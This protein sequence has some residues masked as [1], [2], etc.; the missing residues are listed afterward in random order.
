ML[1]EPH[2]APRPANFQP[3]TPLDLIERVIE[4]MP[5]RVAMI[6]NE[7][8][9]TYAELGG[10][11]AAFHDWLLAR[12]V[13]PGD[14]VSIMAA[15]R[16]EM[17]AA[18]IAVPGLGAV[19][20]AINTRLDAGSVATILDHAGSS[21]MISDDDCRQ[22]ATE[23]AARAGVD[24]QGL[25][26]ILDA[27]PAPLP[28]YSATIHD[29]WQPIC[30]N[31]TSGTTGKPKG[32]VYHH[33]GAYLNTLGVITAFGFD[34]KTRYLSVVPMFHCNGWCHAWAVAAAGGTY[35]FVDRPDPALLYAAIAEH[36]V[37]HIACAPVVLTMM[38]N[39]P[40]RATR[41]PTRR[42]SIGTGGSA[43]TSAL[44]AEL[45]TLGFDL[46]HLYGLTE[47]YGPATICTLTDDQAAMDAEA[48]A[49]LLARQG[50]RHLTASR[51]MVLDE[52]GAEV[53][54]NGETQ[55][56]ITLRGNTLMAG[57]YKD[58]EATDAAFSGDAFRTGDIAVR[59]PDGQVEIRDR[60]K[61][62][63]ISGGENISSLEIESVL[64]RHNAVMLAA[65]VAMPDDTW[66]EIPC[67]YIEP[68]PGETVDAT[69]LDAFC[70]ENL[71]GFKVPRRFVFTDLPKTATGKIQ[72]FA[73][74][75]RARSEAE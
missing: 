50:R 25:P 43:P 9:W 3:L 59:H 48:R 7:R 36:E 32:V 45:D 74:R 30:L 24:A 37:T 67:A 17:V 73:L 34:A 64:H 14:V 26:D 1:R 54:A 41:D 12:G 13:G 68:R 38:L 31:Y 21:V 58:A 11:V 69:I 29:E 56:E 23:A 62:I 5:E 35:V 33:R 63:I 53:P 18:H 65:V 52:T 44:I 57:Y 10:M 27:L 61:D 2:L 28:D 60:S 55:G 75:E 15:N 47:S 40:D 19:L 39:H 8:R 20:N 66:G 70:R 6:W 42:I 71:P 46:N 72:K 22:V 16:P 49:V 51:M 4:A